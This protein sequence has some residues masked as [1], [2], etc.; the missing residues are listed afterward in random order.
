M[1]MGKASENQPAGKGEKRR[2]LQGLG[3]TLYLTRAERK[4]ATTTTLEL[5]DDEKGESVFSLVGSTEPEGDGL[6]VD[7]KMSEE[8]LLK[9]VIKILDRLGAKRE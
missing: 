1:T 5:M 6:K 7:F 8:D 4:K 9:L 2:L 3:H